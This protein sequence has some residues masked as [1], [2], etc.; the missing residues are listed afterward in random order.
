MEELIIVSW[1][2]GVSQII[3]VVGN[4][5][6]KKRCDKNGRSIYMKIQNIFPMV[7]LYQFILSVL[8]LLVYIF[9]YNFAVKNFDIV[10]FNYC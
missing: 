2:G 1:E 4:G 10:I 3:Y 7:F 6:G 9:F 8:V 5:I